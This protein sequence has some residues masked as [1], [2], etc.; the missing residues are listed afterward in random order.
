[1]GIGASGD[2]L[3]RVFSLARTAGILVVAATLAVAAPPA[4][5]APP[6]LRHASVDG[7]RIA[8]RTVGSGRPL[9]LVN[10]SGATLDTWDPALLAGL[11]RFR[12]VIVF[13]PRGLGAST[14]RPGNHIT[15]AQQ[16]DDVAGLLR[17]L[18]IARVDVLG[19]S[20]G[21]FVTQ[22]LLVRH[23][24]LVR[25]AVLV[26][27]DAGGPTARR[28]SLAVR[29]IDDR[30]TLGTATLDESVALLFPVAGR[31][32]GQAWFN[33]LIA[34]PG[35][36][37]AASPRAELQDVVDA[38]DDWYLPGHGVRARLVGVRRRVLVTAGTVDIDIPAVNAT[39][40][41]RTIP[42]ARLQR[43]TGG[44]HAFLIQFEHRFVTSVRGFLR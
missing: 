31:A 24:G 16:A 38:E 14:D 18:R 4:S 36:C 22:E 26:S 34:Q 5:A 44:G 43:F 21:G 39:T 10:G 9:L 42:G 25:R 7:V 40:I 6:D 13:D 35:A 32:A 19:W 8:Y 28:A 1:M 37:C 23:P 27:T 20:F 17:T 2:R 33:R 30:G 29:R 15:I 41:A 3:A 11:G 12:R